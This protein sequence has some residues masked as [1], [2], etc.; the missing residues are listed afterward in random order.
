MTQKKDITMVLSSLTLE[1]LPT[2]MV[3]QILLSITDLATLRNIL[4][5]SPVMYRTFC[6]HRPA[7]ITENVLCS[8]Y[9]CRQ[10][11][12]MVRFKAEVDDMLWSGE[13]KYDLVRTAVLDQ[14]RLDYRQSLHPD[15]YEP[16]PIR[17]DI[18]PWELMML[19]DD[20]TDITILS[21]HCLA[22]A[23]RRFRSLSPRQPVRRDLDP[24]SC[25]AAPLR[26]D[27]VL[28][29]SMKA[30]Q[31]FL[32]STRAVEII[33]IGPPTW[34]EQQRVMR[35]FWRLK[36]AEH[37]NL[38]DS[39]NW[40]KGKPGFGTRQ[41]PQYF[42]EEEPEG[43]YGPAV[44]RPTRRF[45]PPRRSMSDINR[46]DEIP[47]YTD[48]MHLPPGDR[49]LPT[50]ESPEYAELV[51]VID[52]IE[53]QFGQKA[54]DNLAN[55]YEIF[56]QTVGRLGHTGLGPKILPG[57]RHERM[58]DKEVMSSWL[59]ATH[60]ANDE[61]VLL[62]PSPAVT[63]MFQKSL[64]YKLNSD[65]FLGYLG[66]EF[67][68]PYGFAFWCKKRL[69]GYG[70]AAPEGEDVTTS[71]NAR[72]DWTWLSLLSSDELALAKQAYLERPDGIL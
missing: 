18:E 13:R 14:M 23:L 21:F 29:A 69:Q 49:V 10:I 24:C 20:A 47:Y 5:A 33:D 32:P 25:P 54:A 3:L 9:Y 51:S 48:H 28:P 4:K 38:L 15:A 16:P 61:L 22:Y 35:A 17:E 37:I 67:F 44:Q 36:L 2:E 68:I 11:Q 8:G 57:T 70:L 55:N 6:S 19:L 43:W 60:N 26:S 40:M 58:R 34:T 31:D 30:A 12:V 72:I 39:G 63:R 46:G 62:E 66:L 59:D 71:L 56:T 52:L 27:M 64:S 7:R 1:S 41:H 65:S 42:S 53:Q 50:R 45:K